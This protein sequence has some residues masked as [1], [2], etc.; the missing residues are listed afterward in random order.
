MLV[1]N[2]TL[3]EDLYFPNNEAFIPD[4]TK[5]VRTC[6]RLELKYRSDNDLVRLM[7]V[8]RRLDELGVLC[9]LFI[10][11]MP[12]CRMDRKIDDRLFTLK[13]VC[14]FMNN[15]KFDSI[16]VVEP[17]SPATLE[18]LTGAKVV[19]PSQDWLSQVITDMGFDTDTDSLVLPDKGALN[20]YRN[21]PNY[22]LCF[23]SKQ[24]DPIT[25]KISGMQLTNGQI[26][27][28][29]KCLIIDDL[30]SRGSTFMLA[31][32]LLKELGAKSISLLVTHL[33]RN[34]FT[35]QLLDANS[36][37]DKVYA[38]QS[39]MEEPHE[40]IQYLEMEVDRYV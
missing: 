18:L 1:L 27:P 8:K 12:Y 21:L 31:G 24:R 29:S 13:Y 22:N 10:W 6:N 4:P 36:P 25:A 9:N 14:E 28:G 19:Y 32:K 16:T 39:L 33:E 3:L 11:Y 7:F 30:C 38:S 35:G 34:V 26:I 37:I 40:K 15:L 2:G 20:R 23:L 17:H 5:L